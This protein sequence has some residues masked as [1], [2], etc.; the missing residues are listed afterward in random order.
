MALD[1][2]TLFTVATC[3][4]G[5]LGVF[6]LVVWVQE[7]GTRAL[8]WWGAAYLMG[9]SAVGLWCAQDSAPMVQALPN[10][11]LFM[12]CGMIWCGARIFHGRAV[13]PLP[14]CA[15]AIAW[16]L[17]MQ[18]EQFAQSEHARVVLSSLI[19]A[20]YTFCTALELRS[21]RRRPLDRA[22]F[23]S[24][25][26]LL[27]S[28]VFLSPIPLTLLTPPGASSDDWLALFALATLLY[29]VG[30]AFIIVIMTQERIALG[31]KA[32][33]MIDPLTGLYNRRGFYDLSQQ[34][35]AQQARTKAAVSVLAIDLDHFKSI[36]D[37]FGHAVGDDTL[38]LFAGIARANVRATDVLARLGGEEFVV[39]LPGGSAEA[40]MVG[41]RL[42]AAFQAAAVEISS[43][44]I[45]ATVSIGVATAA[46][47]AQ[48]DPMLVHADMALYS[49][50]KS[51]RNR[52]ELAGSD[53]S[54]ADACT[55][56]CAKHL[57]HCDGALESDANLGRQRDIY[58]RLIRFRTCGAHAPRSN[59][60]VLRC[61]PRLRDLHSPVPIPGPTNTRPRSSPSAARQGRTTTAGAK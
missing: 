32:A 25:V 22:W 14:L 55:G 46:A 18:F 37:R 1:P 30:V 50:K 47:P 59:A 41:E 2:A 27:H 38:R 34:L 13:L 5:L 56:S 45:G 29:V 40:A 48:I 3:V 57:S 15:G 8:A 52:V 42:R 20:G 51:G 9:G 39:I 26:P 49:A 58:R 33:A 11:L 24:F 12:A 17:A 54:G 31:H 61:K 53:H 35:M 28:V 60:S 44:K 7:R 19:I 4:T 10:A 16:I 23:A 21:E 43:R 6:I 36:N